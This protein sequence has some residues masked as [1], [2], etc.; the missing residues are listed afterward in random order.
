MQTGACRSKLLATTFLMISLPRKYKDS[1]RECAVLVAR[2]RVLFHWLCMGPYHFARMEALADCAAIDLCVVETT[3]SDDH[4]WS[5]LQRSHSYSHVTLSHEPFCPELVG[6]TAPALKAALD[7]FAP[8]VLVACGYSGLTPL[9][10]IRAFR[11]RGGAA[12]FW[13]ESTEQDHRRRWWKELVKARRVRNFDGAFVAGQPHRRYLEK[14]GMPAKRICVVGGVVDNEAFAALAAD[15]RADAE[16][17]RGRHGLP[18]HYFLF[19]GRF[20]P[21]KNLDSLLAAYAQYRRAAASSPWQLVLVGG[22]PEEG[23]LRAQARRLDGVRFAGLRQ[24]PDLAAFYALA[25]C[26]V[27]PS[28]SEP[29]GLVVNEAMAC[30]LPVLV[31]RQCGCAEDLVVHGRNGLVFDADQPDALT[32]SMLA[33]ASERFD[34]RA[35]GN[36]SLAHVRTFSLRAYGDRVGA[37]LQS[38]KPGRTGAPRA[39]S[40]TETGE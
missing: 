27:L 34:R 22:G 12:L 2:L 9:P 7:R 17:V 20:I 6:R 19:V 21:E 14:L 40:G 26:F 3:N 16:V 32:D 4:H 10:L 38:F 13:S 30:S 23:R 25:D 28:R 35:M 39:A 36:E 15:Y 5:E 1:S 18:P 11:A 29:W 37:F 8:D 24:L 33:L 31:S